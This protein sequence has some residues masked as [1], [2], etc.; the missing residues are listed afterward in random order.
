MKIL[1]LCATRL[2]CAT[3][4]KH[5]YNTT[6]AELRCGDITFKVSGKEVVRNGWKDFEDAFKRSYRTTEE[7]DTADENEKKL[8]ELIH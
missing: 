6:K 8:P 5:I 4:E 7:K 2:L 1:S 3:G